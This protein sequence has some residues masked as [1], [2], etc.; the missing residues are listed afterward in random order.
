[1]NLER[2]LKAA[3]QNVPSS[4]PILEI[5]TRH[6]IVHKLENESNEQ[7]FGDWSSILFDQAMLAD[8]GSLEDPTSFVKRLNQLMLT[9]SGEA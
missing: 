7:R 2:M 6:P 5:N 4:A 8:G 9:L 3:G 1:M